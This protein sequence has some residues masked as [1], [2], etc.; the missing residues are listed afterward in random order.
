MLVI[1]TKPHEK[2][3]C[4]Q[5]IEIF[6]PDFCE[7]AGW[8]IENNYEPV[9]PGEK[10]FILDNNIPYTGIIG[11]RVRDGIPINGNVEILEDIVIDKKLE[12]AES[13]WLEETSG[14]T[15]LD[16][17]ILHTDRESQG[18]YADAIQT[19]REL[20]IFPN[21]WKT[22]SGWIDIPNYELLFNMATVVFN[23]VSNSYTKEYNINEQIDSIVSNEN[24][25]ETEKKNQIKG[26]VWPSL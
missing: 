5:I 9:I 6:Y 25:S 1:R 14:T 23:H 18:K 12:M 3:N 20:H 16:Q 10:K 15:F 11:D 22:K 7:K 21:K 13:R 26:L 24:L 17:Y 8:T 4:D 19:Y 2:Y